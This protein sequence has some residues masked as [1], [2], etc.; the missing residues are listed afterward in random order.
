M[1]A[2][3]VN[4]LNTHHPLASDV[5]VCAISVLFQ[6]LLNFQS[7]G[8]TWVAVLRVGGCK[9]YAFNYDFI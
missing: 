1:Y 7:D 5:V 6:L 8:I 9:R 3:I 4:H 2:D